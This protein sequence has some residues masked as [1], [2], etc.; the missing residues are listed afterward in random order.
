M[1]GI[2]ARRLALHTGHL[3]Y[4]LDPES[5]L[6]DISAESLYDWAEYFHVDPD[7]RADLRA[8]R[9][10]QLL[11][12]INSKKGA[13]PIKLR[14][15]GLPALVDD[16][17]MEPLKDLSPIIGAMLPP[18]AV[19]ADAKAKATQDRAD[20]RAAFDRAREAAGL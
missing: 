7:Y 8:G 20:Q 11:V 2:T 13:H 12:N 17:P 3:P 16:T 9:Q 1:L 4:I 18:P 14:D 15:L 5:L 10:L 19:V 6:D